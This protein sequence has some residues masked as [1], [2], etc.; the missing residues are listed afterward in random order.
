MSQFDEIYELKKEISRLKQELD[1]KSN[2]FESIPNPIFVK[3]KELNYTYCN[4]SFAKM[5]GKSKEEILS[6][7]VFQV[8][9]EPLANKYHKADREL[10]KNAG[11]QVYEFKVEN[12]DNEIRHVVFHKAALKNKNKEIQGLV[13]VITDISERQQRENELE[14]STKRFQE[15]SDTKNKLFSIIGHD[16]KNLLYGISGLSD[17]I[18]DSYGELG[19]DMILKQLGMINSSAKS[20]VELL[21]DLLSWAKNQIGNTTFNIKPT[22]IKPL[23]D[24]TIKLLDITAG[25]KH[26]SIENQIEDSTIVFADKNMLRTVLRNL[27][28]NAIKFSFQEGRIFVAAQNNGNMLEIAVKDQGLGMNQKMKE[29]LFDIGVKSVRPGTNNE[30]GSGLGLIL[31]KDFIEKQGGRI[32]VES[33]ENKGSTFYFTLP[34]ATKE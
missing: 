23:V 19:D 11:E 20:S 28:A 30:K 32:W 24:E 21:E 25:A 6:T 34:L 22:S 16:L 4:N 14:L 7:N 1:F 18:I 26:I 17:I 8:A 15:L 13:G 2:L 9:P 12:G 27:L 3:D 10:L 29:G 31:C 5:L 33:E